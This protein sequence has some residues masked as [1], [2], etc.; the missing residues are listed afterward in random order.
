MGREYPDKLL[1]LLGKIYLQ[2][3]VD[4]TGEN[5]IISLL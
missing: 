5:G 4:E 2:K 3:V 1:F